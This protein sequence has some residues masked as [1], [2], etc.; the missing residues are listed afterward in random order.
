MPSV[1]RNSGALAPV[2]T[3]R[4]SQSQN[5][6]VVWQL[7]FSASKIENIFLLS[8]DGDLD[9]ISELLAPTSKD[10]LVVTGGCAIAVSGCL[11]LCKQKSPQ[12]TG[13]CCSQLQDHSRVC[14]TCSLLFF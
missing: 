7:F 4:K 10:A 5:L 8:V 13:Q 9:G 1:G 14:V 3:E 2:H 12:T 11:T 6:L